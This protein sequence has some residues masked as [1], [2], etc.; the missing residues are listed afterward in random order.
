M[1]V[2]LLALTFMK[3]PYLCL[4][5]RKLSCNILYVF[6]HFS[7]SRDILLTFKLCCLKMPW[8]AFKFF[9]FF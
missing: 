9:F 4:F 7:H 2:L 8:K 1:E 6:F 5:I 3:P